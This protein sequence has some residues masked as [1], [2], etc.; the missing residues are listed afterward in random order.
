MSNNK[1]PELLSQEA[2]EIFE[3][4]PGWILNY[5]LITIASLIF[6]LFVG[7]TII[8]YPDIVTTNVTITTV[9][10]PINVVA[11]S[12]GKVHFYVN[13]GQ[14]V[15]KSDILGYIEGAS[16]TTDVL[17]LGTEVKAIE[18]ILFGTDQT[19]PL[20]LTLSANLQVGELQGAY[21]Q[22]LTSIRNLQ[23]N[24]KLRLHE[25]QINSYKSRIAQYKTL[26][27][28]T[29][30][31]QAIQHDELD[32]VEKKLKVDEKLFNEKVISEMDFNVS[33]IAYLQVKRAV[34]TADNSLTNNNI[35]IGELQSRIVETS[36]NW[37]QSSATLLQ[38]V[39]T[40]LKELQ[41]ELTGWQQ[42]FALIAPSNGTVSIFNFYTDQQNVPAGADIMAVVPK[43]GNLYGQVE[44]PIGG[45]GKVEKGQRVV[46]R[47]HN[48]PAQEYGMIIGRVQQI[49]SMPKENIYTI[50]IELPDGLT[51]TY[52]NELPFRQRLS[53]TAEI[54]TRDLTV[55]QRFMFP[56]RSFV[57]EASR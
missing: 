48:Y 47:L 2:N 1:E 8:R 24:D 52:K 44:M 57:D 9:Q 50:R 42:Q 22:L 29:I 43:A 56:I 15:K 14:E 35:V 53:G 18:N 39:R 6:L 12:S 27:E 36:L 41:S 25:A 32:L 33:K 46:I 45:S 55:L 3:R 30:Q 5:G 51:T 38:N 37:Q 34:Q 11:R 20:Q 4:T 19:L 16:E 7:S 21:L 23:M 10:P 31:Q 40:A 17:K 54:V 49:S 28:Q 13:D 26:N